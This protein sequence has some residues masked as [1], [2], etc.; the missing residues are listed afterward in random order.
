MKIE[1]RQQILAAGA[2]AIVALF[3]LD[4]VVITPITEG[5]KDRSRD[6]AELEKQI[7]DGKGAI[8]RENAVRRR[9]NEMKTNTL[10]P[11]NAERRMLEAFQRWSHDS[12]ISVSSILPAWKRGQE[13]DYSTIECHANASGNAGAMAKFLYSIEKDPMAL[14]IESLEITSR[15]ETGRTLAINLQVSGLVLGQPP[16]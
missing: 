8:S 7:R 4:R 9:W 3:M 5:W 12:D 2:I 13:D 1:N 10:S 6:I 11:E 16:Q 14:R 15:D